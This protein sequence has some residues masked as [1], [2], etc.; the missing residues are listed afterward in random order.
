MGTVILIRHGDL[1]RGDTP[2]DITDELT[3]KAISYAK[4]L[5][6]QLANYGYKNIHKIYYDNSKKLIPNLGTEKEIERCYNT[7]EYFHKDKLFPY[8][9]DEIYSKV[10]SPE[11][12]NL[13]IVVC[14]QSERLKYFP[15]IENLDLKKYMIN[16]CPR[17]NQ[18]YQK[19]TDPLYEQILILE[20]REGTFRFIKWIPTG[21]KK[22]DN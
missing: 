4:K 1:N 19:K 13:V 21:T 15:K 10:F 9:K 3:P 8:N 16:K 14:Y 17:K 6:R 22:G 7:V 2:D 11:N 12:E 18:I 20:F 5:P